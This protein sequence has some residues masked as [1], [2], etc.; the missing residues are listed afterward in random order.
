MVMISGALGKPLAA[1]SSTEQGGS[2]AV[3]GPSGGIPIAM[4]QGSP[5]GGEMTLWDSAGVPRTHLLADSKGQIELTSSSGKLILSTGES[6]P[7]LRLSDA[8]DRLMTF[9]GVATDGTGIVKL[10]PDG[11]GVAGTLGSAFKP[12][13]E[14]QGKKSQ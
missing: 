4:M 8:S 6:A 7:W 10:G 14:I 2:F 13:S 5:S 11:N 9:V 3:T 1:M 12:A